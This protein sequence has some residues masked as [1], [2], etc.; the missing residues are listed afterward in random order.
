MPPPVRRTLATGQRGMIQRDVRRPLVAHMRR[1]AGQLGKPTADLFGLARG[2]LLALV[3]LVSSS[4]L[5]FLFAIAVARGLGATGAGVFFAALAL[6]TILSVAT[7]FGASTGAVRTVARFHALGRG[8]DVSRTLV[9]ALSPVLILSAIVALSL[10]VFAPDISRLIIRGADSEAAVDYLRIFAPFL[11]FASASA[12]I[13]AAT[14]GF[15]TMIPLVGIEHLGKGTARLLLALAA[16]ASGLGGAALALAWAVPVALA[17]VVAGSALMVLLRRAEARTSLVPWS[18]ATRSLALEFWGFTAPRGVASILQIT[19][20]W[21]DTI[22]LAALASPHDAG[23]YTAAARVATQGAIAIHAVVFVLGPL[24]SGLLAKDER[25]R[26]EAVYQTAT[27]WLI[28]LSWPIYFTLI[29]FAPLVL[30]IFGPEFEAGETALVVLALA[31]LVAMACGPVNVVLV[32]AG[33]TSWN[34]FNAFCALAVNVVL[35]LALIPPFRMS[36][37]AIAWAASILIANVLPLVQV[38]LFL[39]LRPVGSGVGTAAVAAAMLYGVLGLVT[40]YA[41]GPELPEFLVFAALATAGYLGVLWLRRDALQ[42]GVLR[43]S[44]ATRRSSRVG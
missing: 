9:I 5:S 22:L 43:Q 33:K 10:F 31:M 20:L 30:G 26:A 14:R 32:M 1:E 28:A 35:N 40:R 25:E 17:C 37:A 12:V 24:V 38:R 18:S 41:F 36:G 8:G 11:P 4:V 15:G 39:G 19:L 7:Q 6:F 29:A 21:L 44:L 27:S 13:V 34:L 23:I 16:L 3:G 2:W 42:L